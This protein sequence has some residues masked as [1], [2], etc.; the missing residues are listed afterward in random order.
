[1]IILLITVVA[2]LALFYIIL[3]LD[4]SGGLK[5]ALVVIEM[6]AVS[7]VF[8]RRYRMPSELGLVLLKSNEGIGIIDRLA[9]NEKA[10]NFLADIGSSMSYGL[11]SLALMKRNASPLTLVIGLALL[12]FLSLFV[13]PAALS[14]L[15]YSAGLGGTSSTAASSVA[16]DSI[17][18][19]VVGGVLLAGGLFL[20]ILLGIVYYGFVVFSALVKTLFFGSDAIAKTAAGG[21]LLLP[22]INLPFFEGIL[23]LAIV[24]VVH[25]GAHAI[26][27]RIAKV[28]LKSSGIVLF[29]VI[30]VGAFVE[31]D[32]KKLLNADA[33][34]Q[35]RVLVAGPTA[36]MVTASAFFLI[37]M[38]FFLSTADLR[39]GAL[40]IYS[41]MP[42]GTLV[43]QING[44]PVESINFTTLSLP[45]NGTV[46][47][48]TNRGTVQKSTNESGKMGITYSMA[49]RDTIFSRYT[50]PALQFIYTTLGLIVALN[51]VVGTV[52]LLPVPLFDG[53]R[54]LDVNIKN[55]MI[56]KAI[57]YAA[58]FFFVLNFL[59]RFF[60]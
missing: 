12:A 9:K 55:K 21:D 35:T 24:M 31:P 30:P 1:M 6:L 22:G 57:S 25:E 18:P 11:L 60:H 54:I 46:E 14:F 4:I 36:N 10:F 59:P 43:Y 23:A 53:Y 8:I 49:G 34:K 7:Q 19:M 16:G 33:E 56:V 52:N 50:E 44:T 13:A 47:L 29:G 32:E 28:P 15:L 48:L 40:Y 26:L 39:Q 38:A 42:S 37:F 58:L 2:A 45:K 20:F 5:F 17:G 3:Q 51:F 41:G 27:T